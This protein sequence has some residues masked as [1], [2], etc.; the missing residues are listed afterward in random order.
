MSR[1][2]QVHLTTP[3]PNLPH[4]THEIRWRFRNGGKEPFIE[5]TDTIRKIE[6]NLAGYV[7]RAAR[8]CDMLPLRGALRE[9]VRFT[10]PISSDHRD[11]DMGG[12]CEL[13]N[14]VLRRQKVFAETAHV[15]E[16]R[17]TERRSAHPGI[18]LRIEELR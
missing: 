7:I 4:V 10:W 9:T 1:A 16:L 8:G 15:V 6:D 5:H 14:R 2:W 3:P 12:L 18:Q 17:A 13:L 11:T